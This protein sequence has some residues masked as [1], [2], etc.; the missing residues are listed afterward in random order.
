MNKLIPIFTVLASCIASAHAETPIL[1]MRST[2]G[3]G[4]ITKDIIVYSD[5]TVTSSSFIQRQPRVVTNL[6]PAEMENIENSIR[7]IKEGPLVR[8]NP[9]QGYNPGGFVTA[10]ILIEGEAFTFAENVSGVDFALNNSSGQGLVEVL[11]GL[12]Q[13]PVVSSDQIK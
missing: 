13:L 3:P 11:R 9:S 6:S 2:N 12:A 10:Y 1:E 5:G 4:Q 8:T 7:S